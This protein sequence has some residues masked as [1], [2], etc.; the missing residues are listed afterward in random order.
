V[1]G[2]RIVA[3][4][5]V[6]RRVR[7][8][9]FEARHLTEAYV[10]WLNDPVVNLY[11][12]RKDMRS[13]LDD[14]RA[15]IASLRADEHVLAILTEAEGHVGNIKFGP[16]DWLNSSADI[17]ILIGARAVWG[18]GVG[19]EAMYLVSRYLLQ[20]IGLNRVYADS[21]NPAF[22]KLVAKLG[23]QV[24]GVLRERVR[25]GDTFHD[26]TLVS[27]LAREFRTIPA[28]EAS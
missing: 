2:G 17:S 28:F 10:G 1:T 5:L 9:P 12:R 27:L 8:V 22:L 4:H 11:S 14:A 15:Y 13:S 26:D 18:Q 3:P 16:I 25:L 24:E 20:D 19:A 23:W 21:C 7:L 6:G